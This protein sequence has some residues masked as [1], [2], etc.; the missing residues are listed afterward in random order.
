MRLL[1]RARVIPGMTRTLIALIFLASVRPIFGQELPESSPTNQPA[2]PPAIVLRL[3][4]SDAPGALG[5]QT[6]GLGNDVPTLAVYPPAIKTGSVPALLICPGGGYEHLAPHEGGP[7]AQWFSSL[8]GT[9]IVLTY[10]LGPRYHHPVM[11]EDASRAMRLVRAHASEWGIDSTR[12]GVCGFS[13]G[14]HLASTLATHFDAG[15]PRAIDPTDRFSSRPDFAILVYPVITMKSPNTHGGSRK[16]LLGERPSDELI[17]LL[18]NDEQ[19]TEQTP[20]TYLV[21]ASDDRVVPIANSLMFAEALARHHV[22]FAARF[23]DHGGHGFGLGTNDPEL[24]TWPASCA[25]WLAH[26]GIIGSMK[27][28]NP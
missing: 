7:V 4:N 23:F 11:L 22:P 21:H 2:P 20:P 17:D 28:A 9:G 18:S 5:S 19:V 15:D 14:G 25:Q 1:K 26:R 8:G 12:I 3:W 13:A 16:N 24:R 6:S 27:S 10:R